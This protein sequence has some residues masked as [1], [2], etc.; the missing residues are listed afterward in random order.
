MGDS[1][2]DNA[3]YLDE[4]DSLE[5]IL[6]TQS[7]MHRLACL[8]SMEPSRQTLIDNWNQSPKNRVVFS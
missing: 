2:L 3:H 5:E 4:H 8:Q 1:I 6:K 7:P